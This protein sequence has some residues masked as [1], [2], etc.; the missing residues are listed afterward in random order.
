MIDEQ[1][2]VYSAAEH[3]IQRHGGNHCLLL[4]Y[5]Y[6]VGRPSSATVWPDK[7]TVVHL[8]QL[9]SLRT[10]YTSLNTGKSIPARSELPCHC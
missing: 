7:L 3:A 6:L 5:Y 2:H 10:P 4:P 1:L 9:Y 8:P